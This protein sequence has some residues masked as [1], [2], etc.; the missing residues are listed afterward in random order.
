MAKDEYVTKID[1]ALIKP[2][3]AHEGRIAISS[4]KPEKEAEAS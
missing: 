1:P 3:P 2:R 4:P